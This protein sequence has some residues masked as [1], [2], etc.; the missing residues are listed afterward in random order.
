MKLDKMKQD[1]QVVQWKQ[2]MYR[3][4]IKDIMDLRDTYLNSTKPDTNMLSS[5][6]Y[7]TFDT[8]IA[9]GGEGKVAL[10]TNANAITG[11]Y[12]INITNL[13][14]KAHVEGA[15]LTTTTTSSTGTTI[16]SPVLT[17]TKISEI[18]GNATATL[19]QTMT[20]DYGTTTPPAATA[21]ITIDSSS[22]IGSVID[23]INNNQSLGGKVAARFSELTGSIIFE[24]VATGDNEQINLSGSGLGL[25]KIDL[26]NSDP[27]IVS[28]TG[29]N[30][31]VTI[32]PPNGNPVQVNK[33]TNSFTIDGVN[34]NLLST[35]QTDFTVNPSSQKTFDKFTKFID[36]YNALIEKLNTKLSEKRQYSYTPLTDDQKK[37]MKDEDIKAWEDKAKTGLLSGDGI[38]QKIRS[39]LRNVFFQPVTGATLNFGNHDIGVDI[40]PRY[41]DARIIKS[42]C[43]T[44]SGTF[45]KYIHNSLRIVL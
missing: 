27:K 37:D 25:L 35:G 4:I 16:T 41:K 22:T 1:K 21:T 45:H 44:C 8:Q 29:H 19:P 10:N 39:S 43:T 40:A 26:S 28:L 18:D 34:Y 11:K 12:T 15:A 7:A 5:N 30:A 23:S 32:T 20:I 6:T 31:N 33:A 13:A 14:T 36:K 17:T 2:D 9:S 38:L 3:D 24:S 42:V